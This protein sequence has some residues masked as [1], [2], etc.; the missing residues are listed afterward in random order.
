VINTLDKQ[1]NSLKMIQVKFL[2]ETIIFVKL[3]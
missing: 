2:M 3:D 1:F